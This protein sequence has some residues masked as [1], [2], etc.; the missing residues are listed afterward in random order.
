[1]GADPALVNSDPYGKGWFF[2]MELTDPSE[3]AQ[4]LDDAGYRLQIGG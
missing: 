4:L 3:V 2:K 1:L